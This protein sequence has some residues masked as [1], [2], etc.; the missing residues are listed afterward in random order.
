M[1]KFTALTAA[2]LTASLFGCEQAKQT[3]AT[4]TS[5]IGYTFD[6]SYPSGDTASKA[7]DDTDLNTAI[8]AYKFFYPTVSI[9]ATWKGNAAAGL[10]TNN[11]FLILEGS[12]KQLVFT[13]NSDTP[14][15]GANIDLTNGPMVV[16]LPPGPLMCVV[17]DLNQ[18]YVMDMGLPG[19]DAGK[20]GKHLILP[21]GYK[22]TIPA[23]YFTGT[24]TTNH[25]LL[26]VRAI[27]PHG[28]VQAAIAM[29]KTAKLYPLNNPSA[30]T[31]LTWLPIGDKHIDFTPV[32]WEKKLDYWRELAEVINNEPPFEAYRMEYG[33]LASLGIEK[34]KPFAPDARMQG[35]L[36]KA[37]NIANDQMRVQSFADRR[38][39]R[40]A[41][42]DR[43][44][45]WATLRPENGTFDT[46]SYKDLEARTKWFYQAQIE[47][48][49]M[50]RRTAAAGSLYWLGTRDSSG[51]FLDGG[52]TYKLTVPQPV[53]AKLFWSVTIYDNETR[54]EI[55][56]DTYKAALRSLFELKDT[57]NAPSVDL[58]FG[59]T[60]PAG[61]EAQWIKTIPGKG[62]FTYFRIYGPGTSAFDGTWK[63]GD[64][65]VVK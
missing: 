5:D 61:H 65:E 40:M 59:P 29:L 58:Y 36:I 34:G 28:D 22:G 13:P 47:S 38:P 17:N 41:W 25:V 62:W 35:I 48:P 18:R 64:F 7:Y 52:K 26:L 45:E 51:D 63:P 50:F 16:E 54:S 9:A 57:A 12:P 10:T 53:P 39:D 60:A 33:L 44:W 21:P 20:G 27:P 37:A 24:P 32:P 55:V 6:R 31:Q 4:Q 2:I 49:A 56:T 23:G 8:T 19:P 11:Q 3:P 42:P 1:H 46:P 30:A 15:E 43:K 14:Y